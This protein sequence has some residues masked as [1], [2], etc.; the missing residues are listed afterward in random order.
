MPPIISVEKLSKT[1]ATGFQALKAVDLSIESGEIFALLGPNGAGKTTLIGIICGIV[2]ATAGRVTVDGHDIVTDYRADP[3]ADR[4]GAAGSRRRS[5]STVW[6]TRHLQPRPVRQAAQSAVSR[7]GA[8]A[9]CRCGTR[10][11]MPCRTLSGGMKRRVMIA[12]ALSHEPR[13][14]V[15]RRA[16]RRRRRRIC[17]RTCGHWC[18]RCATRGV[19]IILTTHYIEEAEEMADRIGVINKGE[20]DPGRGQGGAD[21]QARQASS[22]TL[23]LQ[24]AA[25]RPARGARRLAARARRRRP[26]ARSTPSTR[27]ASDTGVT[28]LLDDLAERRHRASRDLETDA[29]SLED[30]FVDLVSDSGRIREPSAMNLLRRPRDLQLRDGAHPAHALAE[31]RL[32]GHLDLALFRRVRRRDRLA[33]QPDRRRQLRRLHRAGPDHADAADAERHQRLVRHLLPEIHRHDLRAPVG[34]DV[35]RSRSCSAMSARRRPNRS[36]S[37]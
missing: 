20:S 34:A 13:D 31:H 11:D 4:A 5:F 24:R 23:E 30:I 12:K 22:L 27:S 7:K 6:Q 3:L 17:A 16:D 32:A 25:R 29:S 9:T 2:N 28:G 21:A 33:H 8:A 26:P 1:Y 14:P 35:R 37:A 36:C 10:R 18:A 15:P 19:T